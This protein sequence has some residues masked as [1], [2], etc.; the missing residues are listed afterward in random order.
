MKRQKSFVMLAAC[1]IPG[2]VFSSD[3]D[4]SADPLGFLDTL[5]K[6]EVKKQDALL[7]QACE[8]IKGNEFIKRY[9][10]VTNE[11][12]RLNVPVKNYYIPPEKS[13]LAKWVLD[14]KR[15]EDKSRP[16]FSYHKLKSEIRRIINWCILQEKDSDFLRAFYGGNGS[17][18]S[19]RESIDIALNNLAGQS[20]GEVHLDDKGNVIND[21]NID[22]KKLHVYM[23]EPKKIMNE[24][25]GLTSSS[26][27]RLAKCPTHI[28]ALFV[29]NGPEVLSKLASPVL[30]EWEQAIENIK[31][32]TN[33]LYSQNPESLYKKFLVRD[34]LESIKS[35]I[36]YAQLSSNSSNEEFLENVNSALLQI[37]GDL[38]LFLS[39]REK[40]Q[41]W[42]MKDVL[43]DTGLRALNKFSLGV[44][45]EPVFLKYLYDSQITTGRLVEDGI[46]TA[47]NFDECQKKQ[48]DLPPSKRE[49]D[50]KEYC[51]SLLEKM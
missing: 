34:F 35:A 8:Y 1:L 25:Y 17:L 18:E 26:L 6:L 33:N 29:P 9:V 38:F 30:D 46:K 23:L 14:D 49:N 45:L 20:A 27:E 42:S 50:P 37:H 19:A 5:D 7:T 16:E 3:I 22:W 43:S 44:N 2:I 24:C 32:N 12:F 51:L 31:G 21:N 11:M 36:L 15:F 28:Y 39:T 10:K 41:N 4:I 48:S 47:K 13:N 40:H